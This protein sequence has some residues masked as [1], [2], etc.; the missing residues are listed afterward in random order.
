MNLQKIILK[1]FAAVLVMTGLTVQAQILKAN[2]NTSL[3]Q[4]ASWVPNTAPGPGDLAIWDS[5]VGT[6]ANSTNTL[7][8]AA[9]WGGIQ[10]SNPTASVKILTN[11][12]GNSTGFSLGSAG[13]ILT[14]TADLWVAPALTATASQN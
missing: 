14:N 6:A 7:A 9:S 1:L 3:D 12:L 4:G 13:I 10:I 2:N 5:T 11:G 8:A